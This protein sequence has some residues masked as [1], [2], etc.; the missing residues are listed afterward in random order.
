M[1]SES[2]S[3]ADFQGNLH[4]RQAQSIWQFTETPILGRYG[5]SLLWSICHDMALDATVW[6]DFLWNLL[7]WHRWVFL[8]GFQGQ[9]GP[10]S[11]QNWTFATFMTFFAISP[12]SISGTGGEHTTGFWSICHEMALDATVWADCWWNLY[13][14]LTKLLYQ[15]VMGNPYFGQYVTKWP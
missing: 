9:L 12:S 13:G 6:A 10:W 2:A 5:K 15:A 14:S 4:S 3:R 1:A 7:S 8:E 11:H